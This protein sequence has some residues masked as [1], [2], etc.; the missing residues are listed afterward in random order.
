MTRSLC[1]IQCKPFCA[2][3]GIVL[4][5]LGEVLGRF[6]RS[7][8]GD[9]AAPG[10][11]AGNKKKKSSFSFPFASPDPPGPKKT[12]Q[13]SNEQL[14]FCLQSRFSENLGNPDFWRFGKSGLRDFPG[15]WKIQIPGFSANPTIPD[16]RKSGKS[17]NPDR[18]IF[19]KSGEAAFP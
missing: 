5:T 18:R 10:R 9:L 13:E 4:G 6:W 2:G 1:Q 17:G 11:K 14:V 7:S 15:M 19:P 3:L 12:K 8:G 16:F